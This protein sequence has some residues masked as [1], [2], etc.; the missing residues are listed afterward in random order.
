MPNHCGRWKPTFSENES[1]RYNTGGPVSPA[2]TIAE[3]KIKA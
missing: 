1:P 3:S 2:L